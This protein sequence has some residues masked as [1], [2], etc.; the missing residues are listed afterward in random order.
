MT[1]AGETIDTL[2]DDQVD[3][4][5]VEAQDS[6]FDGNLT[7]AIKLCV[8]IVQ[9]KPNEKDAYHL[10]QVGLHSL[11]LYSKGIERYIQTHIHVFIFGDRCFLDSIPWFSDFFFFFFDFYLFF[12]LFF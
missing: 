7:E 8:R 11:R 3:D 9:L 2:L 5:L 10:A 6:F 4:L 1:D 12:F